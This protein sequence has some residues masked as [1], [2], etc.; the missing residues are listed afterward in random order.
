MEEIHK[1][2]PAEISAYLQLNPQDLS[3]AGHFFFIHS[4][5]A[6]YTPELVERGCAGFKA[7]NRESYLARMRYAYP[8]HAP[9][10]VEILEELVKVNPDRRYG[11]AKE[12]FAQHR[13]AEGL[14]VF[15]KVFKEGEDR[16]AASSYALEE[17]L[18][19]YRTGNTG[20]A[21]RIA[22]ECADVYSWMGLYTLAMLREV[23]GRLPE[24]EEVLRRIEIRYDD[25]EVL[26]AFLYRNA[27][28]RP[29]Y[30]SAWNTACAKVFPQGL[31][32]IDPAKEPVPPVDG[33]SPQDYNAFQSY[34]GL[35]KGAVIV[36]LDGY[37]VDN[38]KQF[39]LVDAFRTE[40]GRRMVVFQEGR[41]V[42]LDMDIGHANKN[43]H[44][45][46]YTPQGAKK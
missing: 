15:L 37:K 35:T 31:R 25:R 24:A 36:G 18:Y 28:K 44:L 17:V 14:A 23:Q 4:P 10:Q 39:Y 8:A 3:I 32:R 30:L 27:Q 42:T 9:Q 16:V 33:V 21:E 40:D 29:E 6:T 2:T 1:A 41:Y 43:L 38:L 5:N 22:A 46:N 34:R 26:P 45:R 20:E 13:E 7:F 19:L 12:L 11:L